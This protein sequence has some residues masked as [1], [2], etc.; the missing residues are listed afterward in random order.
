[1][2][3]RLDESLEPENLEQ[4]HGEGFFSRVRRVFG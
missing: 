1:M 4:T 2:V 3:A